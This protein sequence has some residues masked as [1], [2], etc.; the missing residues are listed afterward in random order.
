[1][2]LLSTTALSSKIYRFESDPAIFHAE[3]LSTERFFNT[4]NQDKALLSLILNS[5]IRVLIIEDIPSEKES[6]FRKILD[7]LSKKES[8][9][10]IKMSFQYSPPLKIVREIKSLFITNKHLKS[11]FIQA[12]HDIIYRELADWPVE[13][14]IFPL[15]PAFGVSQALKAGIKENKSITKIVAHGFTRISIAQLLSLLTERETKLT[16]LVL[17]GVSNW[18]DQTLKTLLGY[19]TSNQELEE[20]SLSSSLMVDSP[21]I[22]DLIKFLSNSRNLPLLSRLR[23]DY[24]NGRISLPVMSGLVDSILKREIVTHLSLDSIR[25]PARGFAEMARLIRRSKSLIHLNPGGNP[26]MNDRTE[27]MQAIKDNR[28]IQYL[29]VKT[30][31][32]EFVTYST[33]KALYESLKLNGSVIE[34][35]GLR[36]PDKIRDQLTPEGIKN[37]RNRN[38]SLT[39]RLISLIK[40]ERISISPLGEQQREQFQ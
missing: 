15:I 7:I 24:F 12:K 38:L 26:Y 23:L 10:E 4:E 27:I 34:I 30:V 11:L 13:E 39:E 29:E 28:T 37:R 40:Q 35:R 14:L 22:A 18:D 31:E 2:A 6:Y 8:L 3:E 21:W 1:M 25:Y 9:E 19:L 5:N 32:E 36:L 16:S 17:L 33:L 20:L